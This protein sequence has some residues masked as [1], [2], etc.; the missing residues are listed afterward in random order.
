MPR[1]SDLPPATGAANG[2]LLVVSQG[3]TTR[4]VTRAQLVAGLKADEISAPGLLLGRATQGSGPIEELALG[5]GLVVEAGRVVI[6][7]VSGGFAPVPPKASAVSLMPVGGIE[8]TNLQAAIAELDLDKAATTHPHN[9]QDVTSG[10]FAAERLGS[11]SAGSGNF[12]RGD[13]SWAPLPAPSAA[14][15]MFL[16]SGGLVSTSVQGALVELDAEKAPNAHG[17]AATDLTSGLVPTE[18]LGSGIPGASSYLRGDQTWALLP[19]TNAGSTS[20]TPSGG[21]ASITVQAALLELDGGKAP[22]SHGHPASAIT[23]G[24]LAPERM[25]AGT[26]STTTWLRGDLSWASLPAPVASTTA[27]TPAGNISASNVQAALV[28]LDLEKAAV[29]HFHNAGVINAGVLNVARLGN[30]TASASTWL[31]GDGAWSALPTPTAGATAFTP[32]GDLAATNVQAALTELD[33][34]KAPVGHT[35]QAAS[36]NSGVFTTERLGTGVASATNWLRGDGAWTSLPPATALATAFTPENGL[37]AT[38]AQAAISELALRKAPVA[39][40]HTTAQITGTFGAGQLGTGTASASVYLRGDMTWAALP[41][42]TAATTS[43]APTATIQATT[44]QAAIVELDA[45]KAAVS[46]GHA[47]AEIAGLPAAIAAKRNDSVSAPSRILG[48]FSTGSGPVEEISLGAG[49]TLGGGILTADAA[50]GVLPLSDIVGSAYTAGAADWFRRRRYTGASSINVTIQGDPGAGVVAAWIQWGAGKVTLVGAGGHTLRPAFGTTLTETTGPF[51]MIVLERI[52]ATESIVYGGPMAQAA[53]SDIALLQRELDRRM[54]LGPATATAG[55]WLGGTGPFLPAASSAANTLRYHLQPLWVP[56]G[57]IK[58]AAF[59]VPVGFGGGTLPARAILALYA[60]NPD[61][62][63]GALINTL[64]SVTANLNLAGTATIGGLA[65][66][67]PVGFERFLGILLDRQDNSSGSLLATSSSP[68]WF[69]SRVGSVN[70]DGAFGLG[71]TPGAHGWLGG[72]TTWT[73]TAPTTVAT[74]VLVPSV[75]AT[76]LQVDPS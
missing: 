11:G 33:L 54:T 32:T 57:V 70:A 39:H 64:G 16:P 7:P 28:E 51:S 47:I 55:R 45:D 75:F 72:L 67:H 66:A 31:R 48:R 36:I 41:Q 25:G 29:G 63:P 5:Q 1:I 76:A 50:T 60:M 21:L 19:P 27:F 6:D 15:T 3:D 71:A 68:A 14:G 44:V 58:S 69:Q 26:A 10:V 24:L 2:D 40:T 8:A 65:I 62:S 12:L 74:P 52:S 13:L 46:H 18:R 38:N 35:H 20:F 73:G 37:L 4:R 49:L 9:A 59:Q 22:T 43:F 42:D 30:G 17:H 23:S 53:I 56:A 34:E 61:G